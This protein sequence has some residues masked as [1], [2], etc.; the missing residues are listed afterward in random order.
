MTNLPI[1]VHKYS[2]SIVAFWKGRAVKKREFIRH[3][4]V[5]AEKLPEMSFAINLC[6]DRYL[7]LVSFF[8]I[9]YKSQTN[10]LPASRA[11]SHCK[12]LSQD[13]PDSYTISDEVEKE[14]DCYL[15]LNML[16]V[17]I[18][19]EYHED[20]HVDRDHVA[21]VVFTSG[22]TGKS[23]PNIKTWGAL[24]EEAMLAIERF[25]FHPKTI[26]G[27]VAT[28]PPQHMYGL[29]TSVVI[30]LLSGVATVCAST[31]YPADI[32]SALNS[33][34]GLC[35]LVSTP[36]HLKS[37]VKEK[38]DSKNIKF[39][40]SATATM[41][42]KL[43][44]EVEQ[45]LDT[46]L[47]EIYGASEFGSIATRRTIQQST[48]KLYHSTEIRTSDNSFYISGPHIKEELLIQ[49]IIELQQPNEFKLIGRHNDL[50]KIAGKR[51]SLGDLNQKLMDIE[52]VVDGIFFIPEKKES[53]VNQRLSAFVVA[54]SMDKSQIL[55][56]LKNYID[57]IFLPRP[58]IMVDELP[59]TATGKLMRQ[60]LQSLY[61]MHVG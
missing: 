58:L 4:L 51:I 30:P 29:V 24:Y 1:T 47:Y 34:T 43:A 54:P 9:L 33:V 40:I 53:E 36:I 38:I 44:R 14:A 8:A 20:I 19:D 28:V 35:V 15:Q 55:D 45:T 50:I 7:F 11:G 16:N 61:E 46:E 27:I 6:A 52:G 10:L 60:N 3:V 32:E 49:D 21:A 39:I 26:A 57:A 22:T 25:D 48:W 59:R 31:F 5:V 12:E 56:Q 42:L 23:K 17:A 41:P 13:Y 18:A 2:E 37:C